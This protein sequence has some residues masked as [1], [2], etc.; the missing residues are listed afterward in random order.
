MG[1]RGRAESFLLRA[2]LWISR[3][4]SMALSKVVAMSWCI[5][6]GSSPS[7]KQGS[8]PAGRSGSYRCEIRLRR[9][10]MRGV[11][12]AGG[13]R[14]HEIVPHRGGRG[15]GQAHRHHRG[16][17]A[18]GQAPSRAASLPRCRRHAVRLLRSGDD[19]GRGVAV[20]AQSQSE[21]R[22][23]RRRHERAHLPVRDVPT[24]D[25]R[26][27]R[28]GV[29]GERRPPMKRRDFFAILGGGIVVLLDDEIYA[30]ETG[31]GPRDAPP[32][33]PLEIGAWLHIGE[34]GVVTVYTG[35]VEVGQNA[36]TSLTQAVMEE[37]DVPPESVKMV[38]GDT[39]LTPFDMGTFGSMTT[40][41]M[42][43][44]IRRAAA[45]AR[46][47]LLD[48]AAR[49]W[50]VDRTTLAIAQG[51]VSAGDRSASFGEL[52]HG[53]KW[54]RTI[55]AG[56]TLAAA[57]DWKVAGTSLPKVNGRAIVTGAHKY[58]SEEHTSEL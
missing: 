36:R 21:R 45:A 17:R 18:G 9:G 26:H 32:P 39:D 41:R 53:E 49:K 57:A 23:N 20:G 33:V 58:R 2:L 3:M 25:A 50:S 43:P 27:P 7:T 38:M 51:R 19:P 55:P 6:S 13:R 14:G 16:P 1:Q 28:G 30:Q 48:L 54:T 11:H 24:G 5:V 47:M 56:V 37:L 42:W 29:G 12:R 4:F 31:G 15:A 34:T 52:A 10:T 8:R 44:Q 46:E 35:K 40:P 22:R